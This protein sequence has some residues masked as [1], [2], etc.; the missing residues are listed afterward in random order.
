VVGQTL[1]SAAHGGDPENY[2][3]IIEALWTAGAKLLSRHP[4]VNQRIDAWLE[5]HGSHAE[6]TWYWSEDEKPRDFAKL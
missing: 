1:W 5:K 4:P 3:R 6:P 2:I